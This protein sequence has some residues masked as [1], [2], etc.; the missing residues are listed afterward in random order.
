MD[1][2]KSLKTGGIRMSDYD[3]EIQLPAERPGEC[4]FCGRMSDTFLTEVVPRRLGGPIGIH[5]LVQACRD[6]AKS[7]GD[8]D[9]M[10]WWCKD[11]GRDKESLPRIPAGLF[12]KLAH[13]R[14]AIGFALEKPFTDILDIWKRG[15]SEDQSSTGATHP[16][17]LGY[18]FF[19]RRPFFGG[20]GVLIPRS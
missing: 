3:H 2:Y 17:F 13:E 1:R 11:M 18:V 10:E 15:K 8:K 14:H 9:L 19:A 7:K 5:N 16:G 12:L 20:K 6:C 4:A